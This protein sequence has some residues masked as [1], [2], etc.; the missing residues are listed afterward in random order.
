MISLTENLKNILQLKKKKIYSQIITQ[1]T[2]ST[3]PNIAILI[4]PK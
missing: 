1:N 4:L 2:F 3:N